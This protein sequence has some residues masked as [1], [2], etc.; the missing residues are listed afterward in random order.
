LSARRELNVFT[1]SVVSTS[2]NEKMSDESADRDNGIMGKTQAAAAVAAVAAAWIV[3][4]ATAEE[5]GNLSPMTI[6][7]EHG[8]HTV[9]GTRG[10]RGM[11]NW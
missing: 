1:S 10:G 5:G 4:A 7:F 3:T 11:I 8:D 6:L 2:E 9:G